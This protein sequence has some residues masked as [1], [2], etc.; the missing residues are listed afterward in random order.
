M[1]KFKAL[2]AKGAASFFTSVAS[3]SASSASNGWGYQP[4]L[5]KSL[6]K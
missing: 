5:P 2:V 1:N 4:E 3:T 6:R